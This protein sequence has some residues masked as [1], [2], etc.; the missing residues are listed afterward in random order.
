MIFLVVDSI[1]EDLLLFKKI[2]ASNLK[3]DFLSLY[4]PGHPKM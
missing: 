3:A 1:D 4:T 2:S